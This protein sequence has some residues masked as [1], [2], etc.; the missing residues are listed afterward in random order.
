MVLLLRG[1]YYLLHAAAL[2]LAAVLHMVYLYVVVDRSGRLQEGWL[3]AGVVKCRNSPSP[4]GGGAPPVSLGAFVVRRL[5]FHLLVSR[6]CRRRFVAV[7]RRRRRR[8]FVARR[9]VVVVGR[10]LATFTMKHS[11]I[12]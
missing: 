11:L 7:G 6:R 10:R 9:V 8:H 3:R 2:L 5:L 1:C 4:L 12:A